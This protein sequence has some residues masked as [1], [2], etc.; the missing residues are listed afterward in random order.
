MSDTRAP[1]PAG[2]TE[3][4]RAFYQER[5]ALF[6]VV[7]AALGAFFLVG[8]SL[9]SVVLQDRAFGTLFIVP[10]GW[11]TVAV[12]VS[13][14]VWLVTR[15]SWRLP[16]T[17]L[18]GL[19]LAGLFAMLTAYAVMTASIPGLLPPERL[20]EI[21]PRLDLV[22]LMVTLL[23]VIARAVF[24]PSTVRLTI[25]VSLVAAAPVHGL[26]YWVFTRYVSAA[27]TIT[28]AF[29]VANA[30]LWSTG[31]TIVACFTSHVIYGLRAEV[32]AARR[33]GQYVLDEKIGEGGMGSVYR[34]SHAFLRRP[35]AVKLLRP[36]HAGAANLSRF[37]REVQLTSQLTHPNTVAIFDYGR[38][39]EGVF[40]YAMEFLEGVDLDELVTR[41]GP[42]PPS[43]VIHLLGQVCGSLAEAHGVGLV[44]RDIKPAN[45][46]LC[47][48][49]GV[50]DIAKVVDFGLVKEVAAA[51][52]GR[53]TNADAV[54]GTP[55]YLAP[56]V[57]RGAA[58]IDGRADLYALCA[59]GY[60]LL[61]GEPVFSGGTVVEVCAKHLHER[62]R[63]L[64]ERAAQHV[65]PDLEAL[66]LRGLAKDP[67]GRPES[68]DALHAA[69]LACDI[70]L[71]TRADAQA[72]WAERDAVSKPRAK[73]G[74]A[75]LTLEVRR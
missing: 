1:T 18:V 57:I 25:V 40:Y 37:E 15:R 32:A 68:A 70:P 22:M 64:R 27:S 66:L 46:I 65:P 50:P 48:R 30:T 29:G 61:A 39:P 31:G 74:P 49:G 23:V 52:D 12:L 69:L 43:R 62:P 20:P 6:S 58:E 16:S 3:D 71:W 47:A 63:P 38:T 21:A 51:A 19:D 9:V 14:A 41:Y 55:H 8:G 26:A 5:L 10:N 60:F 67:A 35:T 34:A 4:A 24:V 17:A 73:R 59:V 72:F 53:V 33:M 28:P 75:A 45:I 42:Q 36:E 56:E 44:H 7:S 54:V 2:V 13:L 11:H